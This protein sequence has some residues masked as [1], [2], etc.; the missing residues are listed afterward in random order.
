MA[1]DAP[2]SEANARFFQGLQVIRFF[3][4]TSVLLFHLGLYARTFGWIPNL[5][6]GVAE[7]ILPQ[8]VTVFFVL[9]GFLMARAMEK[10][11]PARF[12]AHRLL[13][14]Y[15]ATLVAVC[16]ALPIAFLRPTYIFDWRAFTLLPF[17][18]QGGA[19]Y[20]L[21]VEWTLIYEV[22]FYGVIAILCALPNNT[23]RWLGVLS[24]CAAIVI[25]NS[26]FP[27]NYT[28]LLPNFSHIAFSYYNFA[29]LT[30]MVAWLVFK[31]G[32]RLPSVIALPIA[33]VCLTGFSW[34][35]TWLVSLFATSAGAA[36]LIVEAARWRISSN[37]IFVIGGNASFGIY[38]LHVTAI[39]AVFS[40]GLHKTPAVI[41]AGIASLFIGGIFG[42]CEFALYERAR[43]ILDRFIGYRP[44]SHVAQAEL[45]ETAGAAAPEGGIKPAA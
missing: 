17:G 29:F 13:R 31:G 1:G 25:A 5:H 8:G 23:V 24:W 6:W 14:I 19:P 3:A 21:G 33:A 4:A 45:S 11:S 35:T 36:I 20:A 34:N 30:G 26:F 43:T 7:R 16:L 44:T 22:F 40:L 38:L 18:I 37:N 41:S 9:S 27:A 10:G 32:G 39:F 42:L 2:L 28:V 12:L 15:P